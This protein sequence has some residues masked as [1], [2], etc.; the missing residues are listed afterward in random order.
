[1]SDISKTE[2]CGACKTRLIYIAAIVG[3]FL[4]MGWMSRLMLQRTSEGG[5]DAKKGAERWKNIA[6]FKAANQEALENYAW[7][8]QSKGLVRLKID[9]AMELTVQQWKNPQQARATLISRVEKAT[10]PPPKPNYE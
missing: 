2:S 1:M 7:Q 6:D 8:D 10:A 3:T 9:R 5:V 4:I